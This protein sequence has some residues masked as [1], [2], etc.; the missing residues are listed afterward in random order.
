MT[1]D[2]YSN[3][4]DGHLDA[5]RFCTIVVDKGD[6]RQIGTI[7]M[8]WGA[9]MTRLIHWAI[10]PTLLPTVDRCDMPW[11]RYILEQEYEARIEPLLSQNVQSAI[12]Y[13]DFRN[14]LSPLP[15]RNIDYR[16]WYASRNGWLVDS[17]HE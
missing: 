11:A 14:A 15:L 13:W 4:R 3:G 7:E 9:W 16:Y 10:Q 1:V 2:D 12:V 6:V 17:Y 5:S 8:S